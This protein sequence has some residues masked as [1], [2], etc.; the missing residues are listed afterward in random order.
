MYGYDAKD[1]ARSFRTVRNNT[2]QIAEEI[3]EEKYDFRAAEGARSVAETLRHIALAPMWGI[4]VHT[5]RLT[6]LNFD[7]F[8]EGMAKIAVEEA[9]LVTKSDIVAALKENGEKY[10]SFLD[11]LTDEVLGERVNFPVPGTP[12]KSRFEM[13]LSA[14]EHEMHHRAQLMLE[15]RMIGIVPHLTRAMQ[16]R[17][18]AMAKQATTA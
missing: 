14:K 6:Q 7:M 17:M 1:L 3:P 13:V 5:N 18:A 11:G 15:E 4:D 10:A 8:K 16:E 2:I 9:K 12:S